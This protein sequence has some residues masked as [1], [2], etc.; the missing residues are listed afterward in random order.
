MLDCHSFPSDLSD[1]EV[2]IG[3]NGDWSRPSGKT[4][5]TIIRTFRK[6]GYKVGINSPYSNSIAPLCQFAYKSVMVELNKSTYME[7]RVRM[8]ASKAGR[9][10]NTIHELYLNLLSL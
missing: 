5:D 7:D 8:N 4:I 10:R 1:V 6:G 9:V 2:C 3:F